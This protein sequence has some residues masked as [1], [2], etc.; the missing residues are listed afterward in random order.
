M[1][2]R[3]PMRRSH[4]GPSGGKSRACQGATQ[5]VRGVAVTAGKLGAAELE[6]GCYLSHGK[7]ASEKMPGHPQVDDA[8]VGRAETLG[9]PPAAHTIPVSGGGVCGG[10]RGLSCRPGRIVWIHRQAGGSHQAAGRLQQSVGLGSQTRTGMDDLD[11]GSVALALR[12]LG[13]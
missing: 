5:V 10:W 3:K 1:R 7:A 2:W 6:D 8:P 4:R 12:W 11:P 13:F 9:N